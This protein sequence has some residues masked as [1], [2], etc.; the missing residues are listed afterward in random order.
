MIR[1]NHDYWWTSRAKMTRV[2][3]KGIHF[4]SNDAFHWQD[5]SIAGTRLWDSPEFHFDHLV[6]VSPSADTEKVDRHSP[7]DTKIF[8]RELIRLEMSLKQLRTDAKHKIVM[9][10]YPPIGDLL[11]PSRV[12]QLLEAHQVEICVFGH[13]HQIR[14]DRPIFGT[15]RGVTYHLTSADYLDFCPLSILSPFS[16]KK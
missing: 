7:E 9:T 2:M 10:H 4:L 11:F 5:L 1:G 14:K 16:E 15:A 12:S 13:L 8:E 3:P 6:K